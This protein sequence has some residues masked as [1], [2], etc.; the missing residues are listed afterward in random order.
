LKTEDGLERIKAIG[1]A[2]WTW[3]GVIILLSMLLFVLYSINTVLMP[4]LYAL[5]FVYILRPVVNYLDDKGLPRVFAL[6]LSYLGIILILTLFGTYIGPILYKE[7]NGLINKIPEYVT[8]TNGYITDLVKQHPFLKGDQTAEFLTGLA[9][10]FKSFLQKA[11][12]SVPEMT[13]SLFG[14]MI[15]F[16]LAPIIAFYILKDLDVIRTTVREMIPEKHRVE[17]MQIVKKIDQIVGGFLKGQALVALTVAILSGI[18]LYALGVDYAILLGF[19]I[20]VFNIIPYLG[21]IVGGA[22]AVIIALDTSWQLALIVVVVLLTVQQIDSIL[23]SPR[24]MSSQVNLHPAVVIFALLAGG[25]LLGFVGM[26]IAIPIA[27][28]GKALYLHFRERSNGSGPEE[29]DVQEL[30]SAAKV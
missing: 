13:A 4:F 7:S 2:A 22:P 24:I 15:N 8:T 27:A 10:S 29:P 12:L 6:I 26:L 11:A 17:G 19:I 16:V 28:V 3:V 9:N 23:I 30:E 20:G 5:V 14:G 18:A 1:I 21:P 25:T